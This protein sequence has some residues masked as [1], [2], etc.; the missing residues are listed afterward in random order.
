MAHR[1][2][3]LEQELR[4]TIAENG[5]MSVERYMALALGHPVW[6]YYRTRDPLGASGDFT[7]APEISQMFGELVG[8]WAADVWHGLGR[9]DPVR[10]IE[11][12][13]GRGTL[14]A[15]ALRAA[16]ALPP[17]RSAID[18]HFV[19]TSPVL[20][21]VQ[22]RLLAGQGVAATWHDTIAGPPGGPAIVI[23][24]EFF[25]AL[26]I[27]QYVRTR[28]GWCERLVGTGQAGGLRFGLAAEPER[29]LVAPA[30]E[31]A[32]TELCPAGQ[33]IMQALAERLRGQG[34]ALLAVDYGYAAPSLSPTLQALKD[35]RFVDP[36]MT[37]GDADL[38][39]HVD[40]GA[41]AQRARRAGLVV[42]G[43]VPQGRFLQALG[44]DARAA[45]LK[46]R[47]TAAQAA[48]IDAAVARLAG[49]DPGM[50]DLFKVLAVNCPDQPAPPGFASELAT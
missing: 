28:R 50:G 16:R 38:T 14:M 15:D 40:F 43:P 48:A 23:A 33:D 39:A 4:A 19:E 27:R 29:A 1:S 31:G 3:T 7:T 2:G 47:A 8:L 46:R 18:V 24:N 10:L 20:R 36:L 37:P 30:S 34:G 13:P 45:A 42:H 22:E 49:P 44:L 9:P 6:G 17:F 12:G 35:H 21:A 5:P 26:P 25:D 32:V 41:L 11:L